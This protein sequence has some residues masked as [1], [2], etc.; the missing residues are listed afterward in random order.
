M[1]KLAPKY[2]LSPELS[3]YVAGLIDGEGC[4]GINRARFKS[5]PWLSDRYTAILSVG[6]TSQSMIDVLLTAFGGTV[7]FRP[8]TPK[9][10]ACYVWSV[11][12]PKAKAVLDA[13]GPHLRVKTA[14]S[15]LLIEFVRDFRSFRGGAYRRIRAPRISPEELA[16]RKRI[17]LAIKALNRPGP[18]DSQPG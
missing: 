6:N 18:A 4:I 17:W 7:V 5:K 1:T 11:R 16:R 12:G 15:D 13:V 2:E 10:K 9:H 8:A 3:G 14:Q